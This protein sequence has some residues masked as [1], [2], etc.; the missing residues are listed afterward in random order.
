MVSMTQKQFLP[1][2][3]KN[4]TPGVARRTRT[5][6]FL[7]ILA[8]LTAASAFSSVSCARSEE[9]P[10]FPSKSFGEAIIRNYLGS[11]YHERPPFS[12]PYENY[13]EFFNDVQRLLIP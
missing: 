7:F 13:I 12:F 6:F 9:E 10:D 4:H 8:L 3:G 1:E 11:F 2:Q 5:A